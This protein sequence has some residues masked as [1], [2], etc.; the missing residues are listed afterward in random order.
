MGIFPAT[1]K[2]AGMGFLDWLRG[3]GGSAE[4]ERTAD[5]KVGTPEE[6]V[7]VDPRV[8]AQDSQ[9]ERVQVGTPD[10][11]AAATEDTYHGDI[12]KPDEDRHQE[13][14]ARHSGI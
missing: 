12:P 7:G 8:P 1:N 5:T 14:R 3:G 4:R 13:E 11:A 6:Q 9:D 2:E 10:E